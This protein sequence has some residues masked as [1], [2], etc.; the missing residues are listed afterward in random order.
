MRRVFEGGVGSCRG[1]ILERSIDI[2]VLEPFDE[3]EAG[4]EEGGELSVLSTA[5]FGRQDY[6]T[7]QWKD[8][9]DCRLL[10]L[11]KVDRKSVV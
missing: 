7:D 2:G 5:M 10:A 6:Q 8:A 3:E 9:E 11:E 1:G 4:R